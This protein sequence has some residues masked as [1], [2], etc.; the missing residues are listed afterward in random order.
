MYSRFDN[1][2]DSDDDDDEPEDAAQRARRRLEHAAG[3][4]PGPIR[5][6]LAKLQVA[7]DTGDTDGQR[8]AQNSM[9]VM[10]NELPQERR[11]EVVDAIETVVMRT[12]GSAATAKASGSVPLPEVPRLPDNMPAGDVRAHLSQQLEELE[13]ARADLAHTEDRDPEAI[14]RWLMTVGITPD[15]IE[16]A[17]AEATPQEALRKLAER[18]LHRKIGA[19]VSDAAVARS[20][21]LIA[22][23]GSPA[24][25]NDRKTVPAATN[26]MAASAAMGVADSLEARKREIAAQVA[27]ARRQQAREPSEG[28]TADVTA[29]KAGQAGEVGEAGEAGH[30]EREAQ[31]K[32]RQR[33]KERERKRAAKARQQ[34]AGTATKAV[35]QP[36]QPDAA[37]IGVVRARELRE[38]GNEAMARRDLPTARTCYTAALDALSGEAAALE[39]A[40]ERAKVLGNRSALLMASSEPQLALQDA[41]SAAAL[42][43]HSGKAHYRV[44]VSREACGDLSGAATA[45]REAAALLPEATDVRMRLEAVEAAL[46]A[47]PPSGKGTNA[48]SSDTPAPKAGKSAATMP[49]VDQPAPKE[50]VAGKPA[51]KEARAD[52]PAPEAVVADYPNAKTPK[53]VPEAATTTAPTGTGA[54]TGAGSFAG[55]DALAML[56]PEHWPEADRA[57]CKALILGLDQEDDKR[58]ATAMAKHSAKASAN[59]RAEA[60]VARAAI[61]KGCAAAHLGHFRAQIKKQIGGGEGAPAGAASATQEAGRTALAAA[62]QPTAPAA[63]ME[64]H[65]PRSI[66]NKTLTQAEREEAEKEEEAAAEAAILSKRRLKAGGAVEPSGFSGKLPEPA[67]GKQPE[68]AGSKQPEPAAGKQPEPADSAVPKRGNK[69]SKKKPKRAA[70]SEPPADDASEALARGGGATPRSAPSGQPAPGRGFSQAAFD[71]ARARAAARFQAGEYA[72]AAEEFGRLIRQCEIPASMPDEVKAQLLP[73]LLSNRAACRIELSELLPCAQDCVAALAVLDHTAGSD[74]GPGNEAARALAFKIR[75]RRAEAWRRLG[76]LAE[77]RSDSQALR[78]IASSPDEIAAMEYLAMQLAVLTVS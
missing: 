30:G 40:E 44:A 49:K 33:E 50:A 67:G 19:A 52:Q 46:V 10:L 1:L 34:T 18:A 20:T 74:G 14:A 29:G 41:E 70:P 4:I 5:E 45:L 37:P 9:Q 75:L 77:A 13:R 27:E 39:V 66:A 7:T 12:S 32:A 51:P 16:A 56:L 72:D 38:R 64:G 63:P 57:I 69:A 76:R 60:K 35:E 71:E 23:G 11:L 17:E 6:A 61:K 15:E 24:P 42:V 31:R 28:P 3:K 26:K 21:D 2:I 65:L 47:A 8:H 54:G 43:P 22:T 36:T 62:L 68:P 59:I 53:A 25:P 55:G 73:R 78:R 58:I 48:A